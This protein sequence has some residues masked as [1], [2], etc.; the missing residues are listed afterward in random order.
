MQRNF[1]LGRALLFLL[2][3][4]SYAEFEY[5]IF[6]NPSLNSVS[7]TWESSTPVE[8]SYRPAS[9]QEFT[10]VTTAKQ[11][12]S[13]PAESCKDYVLRFTRASGNM[14][15][16][17]VPGDL[18]GPV[19]MKFK[20][21]SATF[22]S[23]TKSIDVK[24][25]HGQAPAGFT[26]NFDITAFD[27]ASGPLPDIKRVD[28]KALQLSIG[29]ENIDRL[30]RGG[31]VIYVLLVK[32]FKTPCGNKVQSI[33][34]N[35]FFMIELTCQNVNG[36]TC[37]DTEKPQNQ[38]AYCLANAASLPVEKD[39]VLVGWK[40]NTTAAGFPKKAVVTK[41]AV[42]Y[43][44]VESNEGPQVRHEISKIGM[45]F[46][47][48]DKNYTVLSFPMSCQE[49]YKVQVCAVFDTEPDEKSWH[50]LNSHDVHINLACRWSDNFRSTVDQI[51]YQYFGIPVSKVEGLRT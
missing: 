44:K 48:A 15:V 38:S 16:P 26:A 22:S 1:M 51:A 7:L 5:R 47:P 40:F 50:F 19:D 14:D 23:A 24:V 49:T 18:I 27:A 20:M 45:V 17:F 39:K 21:S 30:K 37:N 34:H 10:K 11:P 6:T 46:V 9:E 35:T 32:N 41:Y 33:S 3:A 42:H 8:I 43:G 2:I 4:K 25:E 31:H 29:G 12:V 36:L 13:I 28:A